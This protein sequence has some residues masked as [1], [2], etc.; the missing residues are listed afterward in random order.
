MKLSHW[1]F[2]AL[3]VC[4]AACQSAATPSALPTT[5][6]PLVKP[7]ETVPVN[8]PTATVAMPSPT[9]EPTVEDYPPPP[10]GA[11]PLQDEPYPA[12]PTVLP[13][14]PPYPAPGETIVW[15]FAV[16]LIRSGQVSQI[17]QAKNLM[18]TLTLTDGR[19]VYA[20]EPEI[21]LVLKVVESC[22][23]LCANTEVTTE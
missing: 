8:S 11:P 3:V 20:V 12:P 9:L 16:Q 22:G 23:E 10:T 15:E 14:K 5:A 18:V 13:T 7:T 19:T 17:V 21:D 4:L 6:A 1:L 2:I